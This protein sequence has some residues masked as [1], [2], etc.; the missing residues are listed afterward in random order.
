MKITIIMALY[1]VEQF[2][3]RAIES[4]L[5][6]TIGQD[7]LRLIM[8]DDHSKDGT[9]A[10]AE[11]YARKYPNFSLYK[12]EKNSGSCGTPRNVALE[13][14]ETPYIMFLDP[15]DHYSDDAC[16]ILYHKITLHN[17]DLVKGSCLINDKKTRYTE[18]E[19]VFTRKEDILNIPII[20]TCAQIWRTDLIRE[21]GIR[22]T[23]G[24]IYEDNEFYYKYILRCAK[25]VSI[26]DI[27]HYYETRD[28]GEELSAT[29]KHVFKTLDNLCTAYN[30]V[31]DLFTGED[32]PYFEPIGKHNFQELLW[33]IALT[34][35]LTTEQEKTIADKIRWIAELRYFDDEQMDLIRDLIQAGQ[36]NI[37]RKYFRQ[38]NNLSNAVDIHEKIV[39]SPEVSIKKLLLLK[40]KNKFRK[41]Q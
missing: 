19:T 39:N 27:V 12:T 7:N 36:I 17:A 8:V 10:M 24:I 31:H 32:H 33:K 40:V 28:E 14:V 29:R 22:F 2:L 21:N 5:A 16:E 25:V 26:P 11:E 38:I 6:Q 1:N 3:D 4:I 9:Y 23:D 34:E 15:D 37:L 20:N 35:P 41:K 13:H 18:E 30:K